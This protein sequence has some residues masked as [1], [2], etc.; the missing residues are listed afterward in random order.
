M[1]GAT[2]ADVSNTAFAL[3]SAHVSGRTTNAL[4]SCAASNCTAAVNLDY[5]RGPVYKTVAATSPDECCIACEADRANCYAATWDGGSTCYFKPNGSKP[6]SWNDGVTSV[7]PPGSVVPPLPR[8]QFESHG[9]YQVGYVIG[10]GL[11]VHNSS[12]GARCP[13]SPTCRCSTVPDSPPS[14]AIRNW[15]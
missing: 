10:G 14:M 3:P 15:T 13:Y 11:C 9:P 12:R 8:R 7:F 1:V 6:L 2:T 5:D 4:R